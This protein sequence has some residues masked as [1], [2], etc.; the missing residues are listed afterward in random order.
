MQEVTPPKVVGV[1]A[2][3]GY[4]VISEQRKDLR[5]STVVAVRT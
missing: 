2:I 4:M 1:V 3:S 5:A